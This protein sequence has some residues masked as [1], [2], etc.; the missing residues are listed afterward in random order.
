MGFVC[1]LFVVILRFVGLSVVGFVVGL[2][3][4]GKRGGVELKQTVGRVQP[5]PSTVVVVLGKT[6]LDDI[7]K[8]AL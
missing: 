2:S 5:E 4:S 1:R 7:V 8:S 3:N 6:T